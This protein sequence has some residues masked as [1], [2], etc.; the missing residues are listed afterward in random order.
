MTEH[1]GHDEHGLAGNEAGNVRNGARPK[2]M[3]TESSGDTHF[4]VPFGLMA[5]R[6]PCCVPMNLPLKPPS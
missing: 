6:L 2:T 1:L 3:L 4:R 5:Y